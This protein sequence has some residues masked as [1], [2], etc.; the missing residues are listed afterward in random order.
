LQWLRVL[1][2][3]VIGAVTFE[4]LLPIAWA[5]AIKTRVPSPAN[6]RSLH[7]HDTSGVH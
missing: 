7:M 5:Y 2:F 6:G 3:A 1:S 4:L